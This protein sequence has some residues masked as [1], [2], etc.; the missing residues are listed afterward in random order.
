LQIKDSRTAKTKIVALQRKSPTRAKFMLNGKP[1]GRFI[2]YYEMYMNL[3]SLNGFNMK[4]S[5]I[6]TQLKE[7]EVRKQEQR[8]S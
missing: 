7:C 5:N 4:L 1:V 8:L 6:V 2:M 3:N